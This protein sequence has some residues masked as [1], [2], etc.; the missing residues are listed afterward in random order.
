MANI[1]PAWIM[2]GL[3]VLMIIYT[4]WVLSIFKPI[5]KLGVGITAGMLIWLGALHLGLS[6]ESL[7]PKEVSGI[8]FLLII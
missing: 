5:G 4:L 1:F 3:D 8:A 6:S 2:L 7:F